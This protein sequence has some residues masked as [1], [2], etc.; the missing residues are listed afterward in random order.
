MPEALT[1]AGRDDRI[2][3]ALAAY[4]EAAERG[5]A[6]ARDRFLACY[7]DLA[8]ALRRFFANEDAIDPL[9]RG[10][11]AAPTLSTL[12]ETRPP[13]ADGATTP[14]PVVPGY[15]VLGELGRGGMGVVYRARD[16]RLNRVVALKMIRDASFA[17]E[18]SLARFRGEAEALARM[19]HPHIVQV[20][21]VGEAS[22]L[23]YLALELV[24]GGSLADLI[25]GTPSRPRRPRRTSKP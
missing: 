12:D 20:F 7:P 17:A 1:N 19:Q 24:E 5:W 8:D 21:E 22:G 4:L 25:A 3:E 16:V 10:L 14:L 6:P 9:A 15:E 11:R 13:A 18:G 2:D 23:P